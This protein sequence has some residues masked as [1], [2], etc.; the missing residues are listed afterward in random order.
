MRY[1]HMYKFSSKVNY[2]IFQNVPQLPY[3]TVVCIMLT[4]GDLQSNE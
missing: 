3:A 2:L 4:C 1:L